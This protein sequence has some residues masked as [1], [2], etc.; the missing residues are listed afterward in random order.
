MPHATTWSSLTVYHDSVPPIIHA[1]TSPAGITKMYTHLGSSSKLLSSFVR[2]SISS[3]IIVIFW[4]YSAL[5]FRCKVFGVVAGLEPAHNGVND[6]SSLYALPLS[7]TTHH[8]YLSIIQAAGSHTS[9]RQQPQSPSALLDLQSGFSIHFVLYVAIIATIQPTSHVP[10]FPRP[11]TTTYLSCMLLCHSNR[12]PSRGSCRFGNY[13]VPPVVLTDCLPSLSTP[14]ALRSLSLPFRFNHPV[15]PVLQ[16]VSLLAGI[17]RC[18][19]LGVCGRWRS[20][21]ACSS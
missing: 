5:L 18:T 2:I 1:S 13:L 11:Y 20:R 19:S 6:I 21:T 7:Y 15:S 8:I 17:A 3:F 10:H 12:N 9:L 16:Y 4:F 14:S